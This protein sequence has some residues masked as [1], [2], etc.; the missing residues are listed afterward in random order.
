MDIVEPGLIPEAATA[1]P[2]PD[3]AVQLTDACEGGP[4][5]LNALLSEEER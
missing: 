2:E 3:Q 1:S 5:L 4:Q